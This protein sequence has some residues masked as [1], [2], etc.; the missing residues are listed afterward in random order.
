MTKFKVTEAR[1]EDVFRNMARVSER[2]R[3]TAD[4]KSI[5]AG[6]ICVVRATAKKAILILRGI[7]S[8]KGEDPKIEIDE[9][10]R[11]ALGV[12][13]GK[14]YCFS[15]EE[16]SFFDEWKWGWSAADAGYRVAARLGLISLGL[17]VIGIIFAVLS[18]LIN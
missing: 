2:Y 1:A 17:G 18:F 3:V 15:F 13:T 6:K 10:G 8:R 16:A 12:E 5:K 11:E 7:S 14:E 9:Q 4:G